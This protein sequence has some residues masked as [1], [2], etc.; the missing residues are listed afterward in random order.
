MSAIDYQRMLDTATAFFLTGERCAPDLRFGP[1]GTH[2][3]NAPR[4]VS[5]ALSVEI[6][7]KLILS[8][9]KASSRGH[10]LAELVAKLPDEVRSKLP[11]LHKRAAEIDTYFIDWRYPYERD[12]LIGDFDTPR[13]AFIECYREVRRIQP[14][15]I[16][17]YERNWGHFE[18]DPHWA[19]P[20]V[21]L[22]QIEARL[23][24]Q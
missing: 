1:Y 7:L 20:E 4:I 5:Y 23:G 16:S 21:E 2:S 18:P 3:V 15:L 11:T 14:E 22:K 19:W 24:S 12:F 13:R 8:L 17:I 9:G 10:G 6:A